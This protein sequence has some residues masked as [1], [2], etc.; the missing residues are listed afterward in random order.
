MVVANSSA[1]AGNNREI[2]SLYLEFS[3][4]DD[5]DNLAGKNFRLVPITKNQF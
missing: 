4:D 2:T 3:S 1:N 5:N